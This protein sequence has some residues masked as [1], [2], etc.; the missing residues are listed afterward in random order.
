MLLNISMKT[1]MKSSSLAGVWLFSILIFFFDS[2]IL[3][4]NLSLSVLL[5]PIWLFLIFQYKKQPILAGMLG[6]LLAYTGIHLYYGM[7]MSNYFLNELLILSPLLLFVAS[8]YLLSNN[9]VNLDFIF[10][11]ILILNFLLIIVSICSLLFPFIKDTFWYTATY[12]SNIHS[13]PRLKLFT[14]SPSLY[15]AWLAPVVIYFYTRILFFK[16]QRPLF[17]LFVISIP[18]IL[19]LSLSGIFGVAITGII[20]FRIYFNK[21]VY[22]NKRKQLFIFIIA[23]LPLL[24]G[25]CYYLF[26]ANP[27]FVRIH[28]VIKGYDASGKAKTVGA[29]TAAYELIQNKNFWFGIGPGQ[30][31]MA[32]LPNAAAQ[33]IAAFGYFG[34]ILRL[35]IELVLF[36]KTKVYTNP[37][38]VW[39]FLF[40]F[41]YQFTGS[42]LTNTVEYII[43]ALAFAPILSDLDSRSIKTDALI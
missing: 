12:S 9:S 40:V 32:D 24:V 37:Y 28:D 5:T 10:R 36:I 30:L 35:G 8:F 7:D 29:F 25:L 13:F 41:L 26:P 19:T 20:V 15:C 21:I 18:M 42:G 38:R 2:F 6:I 22:S 11:D 23:A 14:D 43:W 39:L 16:T 27:L 17:S 1:T 4:G 31:N 33:T 3:P 34:L